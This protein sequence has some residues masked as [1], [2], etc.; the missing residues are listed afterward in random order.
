LELR[1]EISDKNKKMLDVKNCETLTLNALCCTDNQ[2]PS[3]LYEL[4]E[5]VYHVSLKDQVKE[6]RAGQQPR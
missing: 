2:S 3:Q 5:K 6:S 4:N 1:S